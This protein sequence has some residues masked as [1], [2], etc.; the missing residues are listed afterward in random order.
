MQSNTINNQ[1]LDI[2]IFTKIGIIAEFMQLH[3]IQ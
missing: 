2:V 1:Q 3:W